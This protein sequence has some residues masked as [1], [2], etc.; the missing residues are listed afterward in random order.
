MPDPSNDMVFPHQRAPWCGS[1]RRG[2]PPRAAS[3]PSRP[4]GSGPSNCGSYHPQE[5]ATFEAY[6]QILA[7]SGAGTCTQGPCAPRGAGTPRTWPSSTSSPP[8]RRVPPRHPERSTD[9][10]C[11]PGLAG[12]TG[13]RSTAIST[14]CG[15]RGPARCWRS[16]AGAT[17]RARLAAGGRGLG[18]AREPATGNPAAAR[19]VVRRVLRG[20]AVSLGLGGA[21]RPHRGGGRRGRDLGGGAPAWLC[22][23]AGIANGAWLFD[24]NPRTTRSRAMAAATRAGW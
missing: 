1:R 24:V 5:L 12:A 3:R 16:R 23:Q 14:R 21:D 15:T 13:T 19:A 17:S 10:N 2:S 22:A 11:G 9:C 20:R 6:Q 8:R 4:E 7:R 18:A